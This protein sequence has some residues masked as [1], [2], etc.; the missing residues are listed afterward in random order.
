MMEPSG[1]FNSDSSIPSAYTYFGQFV[2]H[3]ITLEAK[4][5]DM[6]KL[7]DADFR[8][9]TS[10]EIANKITNGRTPGLD[11]DNVYYKPA[12]R[13]CARMVLGFVSSD[14]NGPLLRKANDLPRKPRSSTDKDDRAALI[15]DKRNDENLIIAQLHVAF[16]RAHNAIAAL[17]HTFDEARRIL[18]RHYQWIVIKDFLPRICDPWIVSEILFGGN[19]VFRPN[20]DDLFMPFEFSVAAYRFGHSMV[21]RTY[22][23]NSNFPRAT[24]K[25][26]FTLTA[27]SGDLGGTP[28][29]PEKWIIDWKNFV[30]GGANRAR[31]IDTSLSRALFDLTEFNKPMP[32]EARLSVRNLLRGY[33]LRLPTGQAVASALGLKVLTPEE[34]E[35][36]AS[37]LSEAQLAAIR[38]GGFSQRTPLWYYILAEAA[39]ESTGRLGPVGSTI[40]AEVL[41]GL[42]RGSKD[43]IL[44]EPGWKPML[45]EIPGLFT[46]RDLLKLGGVL[47]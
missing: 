24:L 42:I 2:D 32:I 29:L 3:D 15:G 12:P 47:N 23:Y 43:S 30:D 35:A 6:V 4:S 7:S 44:R 33:M 27:L 46:L 13:N 20:P 14:G 36:V 34:I 28:T 45:G 10:E 26:L 40:V 39:A 31:P 19:R 25:D 8:V 17:C 38:D 37:S 22:H 18:R 5:D 9:L 11:L 21:R 16:L 41:I 1:W